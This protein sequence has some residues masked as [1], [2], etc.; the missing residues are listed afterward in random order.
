MIYFTIRLC[1][2]ICAKFHLSVLSYQNVLKSAWLGD[3]GFLLRSIPMA[4]LLMYTHIYNCG[5]SS[6]YEKG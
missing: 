1:K 5:Q 2:S 3:N 6:T 4:L